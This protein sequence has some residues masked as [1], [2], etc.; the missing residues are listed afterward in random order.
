M[1]VSNETH[2]LDENEP[3][4]DLR[5]LL[6]RENKRREELGPSR[7]DLLSS[8]EPRRKGQVSRVGPN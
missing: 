2:H 1:I 6:G 5:L 4:S 8:S 7:A 3:I